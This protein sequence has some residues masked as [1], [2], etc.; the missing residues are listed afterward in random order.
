MNAETY[1]HNCGALVARYAAEL[2]RALRIEIERLENNVI[3]LRNQHRRFSERNNGRTLSGIFDVIRQRNAE[4]GDMRDAR[5]RLGR[6]VDEIE[7]CDRAI[8]FVVVSGKAVQSA[9]IR[10]QAADLA[11]ADRLAHEFQDVQGPARTYIAQGAD[12]ATR[13]A[14]SLADI[15]DWLTELMGYSPT[16]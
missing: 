4:A 5:V 12:A 10:R 11:E 2:D 14:K 8:E 13:H 3:E 1:G 7:S 9:I 16:K 6:A 15:K